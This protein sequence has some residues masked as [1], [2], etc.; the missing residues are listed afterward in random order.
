M[1]EGTSPTVP[2]ST[3]AIYAS[4]TQHD[5]QA[6]V[7]DADYIGVSGTVCANVTPVTVAA[8]VTTDQLLM[9]CTLAANDLNTTLRTL[10]IFAAGVYS[11]AATST[12]QITLK[13]KL[14]TVS[15]CGSGTVISLLNIQSTALGSVTVTNNAWNITGEATVQTAGASAAFESHGFISIDLGSLTTAA[16]S[17]FD[18]T[19]T[20]TAGTISSTGGLFL[21]ITGAY[22]AGSTSNSMTERQ[23]VV[24]LTN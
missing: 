14:C 5:V 1:G 12:A 9:S 2:A 11:T 17:I 24:E 4:S 8:N 13:A 20:A 10:K 19:N 15:G 22:S 16:D 23:L 7:N 21:Q 3:E 6:L 18:D